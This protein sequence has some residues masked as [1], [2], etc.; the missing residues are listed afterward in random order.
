M[1]AQFRGDLDGGGG[2]GGGLSGGQSGRGYM[3]SYS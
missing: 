2:G 3:Y 1:G